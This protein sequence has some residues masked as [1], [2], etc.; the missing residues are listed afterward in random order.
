MG[1]KGSCCTSCLFLT[2][3]GFRFDVETGDAVDAE[4]FPEGPGALAVGWPSRGSNGIVELLNHVRH[5]RPAWSALSWAVL[6]C[7]G[8]EQMSAAVPLPPA[9]VVAPRAPAIRPTLPRLHEIDT[10]ADGLD[11]ALQ[12]RVTGFEQAAAHAP[13][14]APLDELAEVEMV[15][16]TPVAQGQLDQFVQSGGQVTYIYRAVSYGWNGLLPLSRVR[17]AARRARPGLLGMVQARPVQLHMDKAARTGRVRPLV[18]DLGYDGD[19]SITIAIMDSGVDDG[20][21]D[22]AGRMAYWHDYTLDASPT[23][24]SVVAHGSHVAGI[25]LGTGVSSGVNPTVIRWTDEGVFP[26][27]SDSFYPSVHEFPPAVLQFNWAANMVWQ[28][29]RGKKA[30]LGLT[31]VNA[32]TFGFGLFAPATVGS[33]SP[34]NV[35]ATK[36]NPPPGYL[37]LYSAFCSSSSAAGGR[38]YSNANTVTAT[39]GSFNVGDGYTL[40]RGLAPECRWAGAK[41][42]PDSGA[43]AST[44]SINAA[45]DDLVVQRVAHNIKIINMSFGLSDGATDPTE[46]AKVNTAADNG[47][48]V[49]IS[50]GNDGPSGEISD[51]GRA[52]KAITV[53][54]ANDTNQLT[55]YTSI[56]T[57]APAS[58]EDHKPDLIA[59]GGSLTSKHSQIMSVD[60]NDADAVDDGVTGLPDQVPDDYLNIS[61]TSMAAPFVAGAAALV[62]DAW[63]TAGHVWD[64]DSPTDALFVKM[65]LCASATETN[66]ARE[67][68]SNSPTLE[69]AINNLATGKNKDRFEGYGMINPDAA[70]EALTLPLAGPVTGSL[71]SAATD[72]RA[73]GGYIDLADGN[74]VGLSLSMLGGDY[75]L[76]LYDSLPEAKGNPVILASSTNVGTSISES[77]NYSP[78]MSRRAYVLVKRVSGGGSFTLSSSCT[79]AGPPADF[80]QDCDVDQD[81]FDLLQPCLSG[82]SLGL[83]P[84]CETRD[85]N[86]DTSV[87]QS[88]FGLFQRCLSGPGTPADSNCLN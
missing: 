86:A 8:A 39:S 63:Q 65:L 76:Y 77:I 16:S 43:G 46:R 7:T 33:G 70:I 2:R 3:P 52:A 68:G 1:P 78:T 66:Q 44:T 26:T 24:V 14:A 29:G 37:R 12:A 45:I 17:E 25:A 81:D 72:R 40:F 11:D 4:L 47:I 50:A 9:R 28:S 79:G 32:G 5:L 64:F 15:F 19:P 75:D 56:W 6:L 61:G 69:R 48:V 88:D 83:L 18:W 85:L 13:A 67:S 57:D 51:P 30:Q 31:A 58:G 55:D 34:I 62:I 80:D 74:P 87:D 59:P 54:S 10:D 23:P 71:G 49:C 53:G 21:T 84:G 73:A 60:S 22:L 27:Q 41:I 20:H 82:P 36:A 38:A 35:S 42:F